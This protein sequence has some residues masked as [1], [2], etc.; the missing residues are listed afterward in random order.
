MILRAIIT[1]LITYLFQPVPSLWALC[2]QHHL[3]IP[4]RWKPKLSVVTSAVDC[5]CQGIP[6]GPLR[7]PLGLGIT[8]FCCCS[9]VTHKASNPTVAD[10]KPLGP[11]LSL[12]LLL[13]PPV[14]TVQC[15]V[16]LLTPHARS[17]SHLLPRPIPPPQSS[18]FSQSLLSSI[19]SWVHCAPLLPP[20]IFFN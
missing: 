16:T 4:N 6:K 17:H 15:Y 18:G 20:L 13:L 14:T 11:C 9:P 8:F 3:S 2:G 7:K 12:C 5:S 1:E 10:S 19:T